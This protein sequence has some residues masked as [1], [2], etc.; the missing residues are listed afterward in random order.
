M[1]KE[2]ELIARLLCD[3]LEPLRFII[4]G[5]SAT[6]T[7]IGTALVLTRL[8]GNHVS[9]YML[10]VAAFCTAFLVSFLGHRYVTF[11]RHGSVAKFLSVALA[12]FLLNNIILHYGIVFGLSR[13]VALIIATLIVACGTY[14]ASKIWAFRSLLIE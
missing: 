2:I 11:G 4:V 10:N 8:V 1:H 9:I 13:L 7:H 14:L 12:G 3:R 5:G 6:V